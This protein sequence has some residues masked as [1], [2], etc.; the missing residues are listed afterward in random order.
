MSSDSDEIVLQLVHV[1]K[2]LVTVYFEFIYQISTS[3]VVLVQPYL[4]IP[5][6]NVSYTMVRVCNVDSVHSPLCSI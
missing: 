6:T 2:S 4:E 5:K 3:L 1:I